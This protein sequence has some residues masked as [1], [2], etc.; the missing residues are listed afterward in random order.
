MERNQYDVDIELGEYG[1]A[2]A[3][4]SEVQPRVASVSSWTRPF[5]ILALQAGQKRLKKSYPFMSSGASNARVQTF[6][7][8]TCFQKLPAGKYP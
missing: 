3:N 8:F 5:R 2:R 4:A 6:D 1:L 7:T